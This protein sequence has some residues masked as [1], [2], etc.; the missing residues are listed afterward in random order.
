MKLNETLSKLI[1][2]LNLIKEKNTLEAQS[3]QNRNKN[4]NLI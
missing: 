3:K 4:K 1:N 2:N